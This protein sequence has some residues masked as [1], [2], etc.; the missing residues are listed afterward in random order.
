MKRKFTQNLLGIIMFFIGFILNPLNVSA[1]PCTAPT[2]ITTT[3][4]SN[5]TATL[6]WNID[7]NVDHYR[8][9]YKEV[10]TAG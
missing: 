8:V 5:F 2:A 1:Q 4:V 3:N 7:S 10:G 6:N 9:K